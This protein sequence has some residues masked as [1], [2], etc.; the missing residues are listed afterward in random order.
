MQAT[1]LAIQQL[2]PQVFHACHV[3]HLRRRSNAFRL[4]ESDSAILAHIGPAFATSARDL[5]RHLGIGAPTM[6]AALQRLEALGYVAR[7][8]RTKVSPLRRLE[9][10]ELG[11]RALQATSVLDA[12]R[13]LALLGTLTPRERERAVGGLQL[14]ARGARALARKEASS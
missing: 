13:L 4:S 10:T 1:V 7:G 12:D 3:R 6:S 14:L 8:G 2:Y 9:L 5:A 11:R